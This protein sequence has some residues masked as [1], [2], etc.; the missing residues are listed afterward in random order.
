[1]R[2]VKIYDTTLRD[3]AQTFGVSFSVEDKLAI[4]EELDRFGVEYIEAGY[5]TSNPKDME[6]FEK[7]QGRK[8]EHAKI[9]AFGSTRR[10]NVLASEDKGLQKLI[11]AD[12]EYIAIYGKSWD[13]HVTDT[14]HTS[15]EENLNMIEESIK[16]LVDENRKVIFDAEHFFDGYS[17]NPQYA[18]K[19][20]EVALK[21]GAYS[22]CLCDTNGG[23]LP[24]QINDIVKRVKEV[25][26]DKIEL[27][28]HCHN[29]GGLAVANSIQAVLAGCN[30]IQGTYTG[31]GERCGNANL[32]TIIPT[33]EIKMGYHCLNDKEQL[34][35]LVSIYHYIS[36]I[37]NVTIDSKM[38]YVGDTAFVHKGGAHI[39]GIMKNPKSFEHINP[40]VVGNSRKAVVS[41]QAGK[42]AI[43]ELIHKIDASIAKEDSRVINILDRLK[44]LEYEGYQF[45][46]AEA[47]FLLVISEELGIYKEPFELED[48]KV[49]IS[50]PFDEED[51]V[52]AII[53]LRVEGKRDLTVAEGVGPVNA[54]DEALRK[55]LEKF[56]PSLKKMNLIDYKVRVL[57]TKDGTAKPV[58]V[59]IKS[60]DGKTTWDTIGVS[61]NI[62]EASWKAL[63]DSIEYKLLK[64]KGII[65]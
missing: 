52:T 59:L 33:L 17:N 1:M 4:I 35:N 25:I 47:S 32:S 3:G 7:L 54:L 61:R 62:I 34:K 31:I 45:E 19:T 37:S 10:A 24:N 49:T 14:I 63:V 46:S 64:D 56:Y 8:L 44:L 40:S 23:M 15:L 48:V 18:M 5:P 26:G 21:A 43:L 30:Q 42:S 2:Q 22:I 58:R 36:E 50:T 60:T 53:K 16:L 57:D 55:A 11:E 20:I 41:E 51:S 13:F 65:Q 27:G 9:V 12:T 29:D 28:I 6:I 39:D 38:P